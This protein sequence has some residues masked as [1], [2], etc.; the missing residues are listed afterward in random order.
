MIYQDVLVADTPI[1]LSPF[2]D[3]NCRVEEPRQ[4]GRINI[5]DIDVSNRWHAYRWDEVL[6]PSLRLLRVCRQINKEATP[7]YYAQPFRFSSEYGWLT[8]Y[9]WLNQIGLRNRQLIKDITICHPGLGAGFKNLDDFTHLN[10]HIV[11]ID[12]PCGDPFRFFAPHHEPVEMDRRWPGW[13]TLPH[14]AWVLAEIQGLRRLRLVIKRSNMHIGE[15]KLDFPSLIDHPIHTYFTLRCTELQLST[16]NFISSKYKQNSLPSSS[17]IEVT[18]RSPVQQ[19]AQDFFDAITKQ[20]WSVVEEMYDCN[21]SYPVEAG[22]GCAHEE[23]CNWI[24]NDYG[25]SVG[26]CWHQAE[27]EPC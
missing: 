25:L 11:G 1:E 14:P 18:T 20:G 22:S 3:C 7:I 21:N 10:N 6:R 16:I 26:R 9:H 12:V 23:L 17:E 19:R 13:G 8:L 15:E 2:G 24:F 5:N 4:N 27:C